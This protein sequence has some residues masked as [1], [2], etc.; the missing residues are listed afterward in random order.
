MHYHNGQ[1][2]PDVTT[3]REAST[4]THMK[5]V[6]VNDT[7]HHCAHHSKN[8]KISINTRVHMIYKVLPFIICWLKSYL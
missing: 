7:T 5:A 2:R 8:Q 3:R 4:S 6:K 1:G